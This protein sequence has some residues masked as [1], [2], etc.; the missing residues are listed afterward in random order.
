MN[1]ETS[2]SYNQLEP[3]KNISTEKQRSNREHSYEGEDS[4][5]QG[6]TQGMQTHSLI[7]NSGTVQFHMAGFCLC[8]WELLSTAIRCVK[9]SRNLSPSIQTNPLPFVSCIEEPETTDLAPSTEVKIQILISVQHKFKYPSDTSAAQLS[10][11]LEEKT[12]LKIPFK[13]TSPN[14]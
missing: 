9:I 10:I 8:Q 1:R 11:L 7:F 2:F 6:N 13:A 3:L 4:K 5:E 12:H 14:T